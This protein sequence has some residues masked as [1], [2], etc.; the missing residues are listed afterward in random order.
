LK[1]LVE[2]HL[3]FQAPGIT[4]EGMYQSVVASSAQATEWTN[5][6][7]L[8]V[9][10]RTILKHMHNS[11]EALRE[12]AKGDNGGQTFVYMRSPNLQTAT[13]PSGSTPSA[14][15]SPTTAA[16]AHQD[17]AQYASGSPADIRNLLWRPEEETSLVTRHVASAREF[18][19]NDE[20]AQAVSQSNALNQSLVEPEPT[21]GTI[22]TPGPERPRDQ[23]EPGIGGEDPNKAD[24]ELLKTA[25]RLRA[26]FETVTDELSTSESQLQQAQTKCLTLERQASEQR[27]KEA[28]LLAD[29]QRLR[30]KM[31]KAEREA[32]DCQK[33]ADELEK[34]ADHERN[35][36]KER[37]TS[38]A[39]TKERATEV[40]KRLQTIRDELKI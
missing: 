21:T 24:M 32:A 31:M 35:S 8:R 17:A 22:D 7:T 29:V 1:P 23:D 26:E 3:P 39:A 28:E 13:S 30:E 10:I 2:K 25:R 38:I 18:P 12:P 9:H 14:R 6:D 4:T 34:A 33:G 27:S 5:P 20:N 11:G 40:D 19:G 16:H 37:E 15:S 36:C